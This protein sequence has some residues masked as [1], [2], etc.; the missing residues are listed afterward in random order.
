MK[1]EDIWKL[2][3][4]RYANDY[5]ERYLCNPFSQA[6][7]DTELGVLKGLINPSS[8]WLDLGSG[9]GYFLS[10]FPG[11]Q[12]AG[13]DASPEMIKL[14][15]NA[16][17]DA[18]FI[19]EG[20]IRKDNPEWHS[21][22][23]LVTC[24]W[25]A[26]C[27]VDSVREVE[28]V[29]QN[30]ILWT[31]TGGA[32]FLPV[33]DIEDLRP[34]V[35][36]PYEEANIVF[37]GKTAVTSITWTWN[38]DNG[39]THENLVSPAVEYLVNLLKPFFDKIEVVRYPPF[40]KDWVSRKAILA[41]GRRDIENAG[42]FANII[43]QQVPEAAFA[44]AP[45]QSHAFRVATSTVSTKQLIKELLIRTRSGAIFKSLARKVHQKILRK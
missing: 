44:T 36:L 4:H 26:Y 21:A 13:L 19:T 25:G 35:K 32:I 38:E 37:G 22:W 15:R 45:N 43:W 17:P 8:R 33:V 42:H 5:N 11:I 6:N 7:T 10:Q 23:T 40:M 41:T 34:N 9:T 12:R 31:K 16:N 29:I 30:M 20:D 27:Y 2:Y 24:M 1:K 3:D 18:L 39:K 14:A 28:Q